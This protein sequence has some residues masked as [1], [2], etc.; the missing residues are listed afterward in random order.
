MSQ[1]SSPSNHRRTRRRRL[2]LERLGQRRVLAA[3]TGTVFQDL[4]HSTQREVGEP[5]APKRL[6]YID[7][8]DNAQLDPG[9]QYALGEVDGSFEFGD[10]ADGDY[11]VRLFSGT[12]SQFQTTPLS[13]R[14][15]ALSRPTKAPSFRFCLAWT[16][17]S[18]LPKTPF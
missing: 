9:E 2:L 10:L 8:N 6:L 18:V 12:D 15:E 11:L 13:P 16:K 5:V 17:F 14:S 4:D 3:I 7:A 1:G